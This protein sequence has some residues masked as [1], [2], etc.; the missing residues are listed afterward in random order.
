M[1]EEP[2]TPG[3]A[4]GKGYPPPEMMMRRHGDIGQ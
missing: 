4:P 2:E 1:V 3:N